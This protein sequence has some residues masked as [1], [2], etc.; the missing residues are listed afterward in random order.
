[1]LLVRNESPRQFISLYPITTIIVLLNTLVFIYTSV[2]GGLSNQEFLYSLGGISKEGILEGEY[3]RLFSYAFIHN[4]SLHFALNMGYMLILNPPIEKILGKVK[5][6]A[7]FFMSILG[8][9]AL[10][11]F[12]SDGGAVGASGFGYAIFGVYIAFILMKKK[13]I[14]KESRNAILI[15]AGV[16]FL[17]T[18]TIEK[19]SILGHLGGFLM[20]FILGMVFLQHVSVIN[21]YEAKGG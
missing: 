3:Y 7:L 10:I 17:L 18:F 12:K 6:I 19:I 21:S 9:A 5:Y 13:L 4:G 16:G 2:K 14:D 11:V 20:G 15:L 1:M 8:S